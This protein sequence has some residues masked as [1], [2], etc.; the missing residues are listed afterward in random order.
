MKQELD[1]WEQ[2]IK[3]YY[4]HNNGISSAKLHALFCHIRTRSTI[5]IDLDYSTEVE[6]IVRPLLNNIEVVIEAG[7]SIGDALIVHS[8]KCLRD[9][10]EFINARNIL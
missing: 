2:A 1:E 7:R 3:N 4:H 6:S 5:L 9:L 10:G 8:D